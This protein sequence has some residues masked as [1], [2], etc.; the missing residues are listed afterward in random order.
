MTQAPMSPATGEGDTR[1]P[2]GAKPPEG[3]VSVA[4]IVRA[5]Y[6]IATSEELVDKPLSRKLLGTALVVFRNASGEAGVLLDRCAHRNVPLS[7]GRVE[8]KNVE[9]P[10]H[11]WQFDPG[12]TCRR[13]PGLCGA[14]E[15]PS[16]AVQSYAVREQ[17]GYV[18]IWGDPD[19]EA[20]GSPFP[21]PKIDAA[22]YTTVRRAVEA[23]GTLHA[24]IENALDVPHT[25]FLHKGL[26]RGSGTTNVIKAIVTRGLD[27]VQTEYVGE[28]RPEG[29]V[30]RLLSPS[31]GM[32]THFDRFILPSIAQVE[33][34][35]GDEN[36]ILVTSIGTPVED[37]VTRL[38]AVVTFR[39]RIP[40][41]AVK[42]VL[43]PV[44]MKIFSQDQHILRIQTKAIRDFGGEDF[45]STE[46]DLMGAQIWRL[47]R[48][49]EQGK[50][51]KEG[52]EDWRREIELEV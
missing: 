17:D 5:W 42:P 48:R 44:A 12:G 32:V 27:R 43:D 37:F 13:V 35:I 11:G 52:D 28:P 34:L 4:R 3:R 15:L 39:T 51:A 6:V 40:G 41:W 38:Y 21:L 30:G 8:G 50:S 16:R 26:F 2:E 33:Y 45:T 20:V 22:G 31:G 1:S 14:A 36:H 47:M 23:E 46:I 25:A 7:L 18:W 49:A 29:M 9:C 19:S 24:T 10:Y